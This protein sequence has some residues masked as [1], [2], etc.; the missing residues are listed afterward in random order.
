MTQIDV[1]HQKGEINYLVFFQISSG[2]RGGFQPPPPQPLALDIEE[3]L[4]FFHTN[5]WH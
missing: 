3:F 1:M 5:M 2:A 4:N